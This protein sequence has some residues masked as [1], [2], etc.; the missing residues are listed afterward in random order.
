M[1]PS[2]LSLAAAVSG[3]AAALVSAAPALG[4]DAIYGGPTRSGAPI[5]VKADSKAQRLKSVTLYWSAKCGDGSFFD[6]GGQ[7][8]PAVPVEGFAPGRRELAVSRNAKGRFEGQQMYAL[9]GGAN[10]AVI[11]VKVAGK[12]AAKRASGT[13]SAIIK[14][15][16]KATSAEVTSCQFDTSWVATRKP[17]TI[18]AG[19][20]SQ[21]RPIVLNTSTTVV[22][23]VITAWSAPCGGDAGY[24]SG[25]DHWGGFKIKS[26][27]S[28]GN[29]FSNDATDPDGTKVHWDYAVAGKV[30]RA[31]AKGTL[32]VKVT[33]TD[34]AGAVTS[35]DSGNVTWKAATG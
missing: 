7:L 30:R 27:G 10:I 34:P 35:C 21:D 5:V 6:G 2:L 9:D 25:P 3:T 32:Q 19:T 24:F 17:G 11:Q 23:D 20:T 8:T 12:L 15:A 13:L 18:F 22:N 28:F 26:T 31:D 14:I 1:R 16:D 4:A 33:T 29:P